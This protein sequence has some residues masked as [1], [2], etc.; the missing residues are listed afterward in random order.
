MAKSFV[1]CPSPVALESLGPLAHP[2]STPG[3]GTLSSA[4]CRR[5][6]AMPHTDCD[7]ALRTVGGRGR[8]SEEL[9]RSR[10]PAVPAL[11]RA[12]SACGRRSPGV[13]RHRKPRGPQALLC[14]AAFREAGAP[15]RWTCPERGLKGRGPESASRGRRSVP[16]AVPCHRYSCRSFLPPWGSPE[17]PDSTGCLPMA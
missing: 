14:R 5:F 10:G 1:R 9:S 12:D 3:P 11:S 15:L 8:G 17:P 13:R 6:P 4:V 2:G 16:E 7:W